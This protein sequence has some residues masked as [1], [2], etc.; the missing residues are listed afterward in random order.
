MG[1]QTIK[2]YINNRFEVLLL[3]KIFSFKFHHIVSRR[4]WETIPQKLNTRKLQ[5]YEAA[6]LH[7]EET[8]YSRDI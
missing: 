1:K 7:Y 3:T 4:Q 6:L 8:K 2:R 5:R